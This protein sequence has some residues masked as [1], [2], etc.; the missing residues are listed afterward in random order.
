MPDPRK[1]TSVYRIRGLSAD[2]IWWLGRKRV[3]APQRKP[4]YAYAGVQ[5]ADL[6][7][8]GL[9]LTCDDRPRRHAEIVNWPDEKPRQKIL[10][11]QL[12][13]VAVLH[14][15][16][17]PHFTSSRPALWPWPRADRRTR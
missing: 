4:L 12:A 16:K 6:T 8:V 10:A 3:A 7:R 11:L 13:G 5:P 2:A 14:A 1:T 17:H 9:A 15:N